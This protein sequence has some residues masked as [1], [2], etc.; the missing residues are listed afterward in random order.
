MDL[1]PQIHS[2]P[3]EMNAQVKMRAEHLLSGVSAAAGGA[4]WADALF[5]TGLA[6][7]DVPEAGREALDKAIAALH[8][9]PMQAVLFCLGDLDSAGDVVATVQQAVRALGPGVLVFLEKALLSDVVHAASA[10]SY[11]AFLKEAFPY[12]KNVVVTDFFGSLGELS[13]KR[14]AWNELKPAAKV[15]VLR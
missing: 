11:T 5:V 6:R 8:Y 4:F 12:E 13:L 9:S 2:T 10:P 7:A 1:V 15:P 14:Q 3:E